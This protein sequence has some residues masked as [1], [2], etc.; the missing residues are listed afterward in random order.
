MLRLIAVLIFTCFILCL[1]AQTELRWPAQAGFSFSGISYTGD[2]SEG[3]S[4][5]S[6]VYPGANFS[7]QS[8][9][10][11]P[12]K[13]QLNAG[14]GKFAE[15]Y[16]TDSPSIPPGVEIP[17][18]IETSFIY[19]DLRLRY[20]FF[21]NKSFQPYLS[22][23]AGIM[24]FSPKDQDGKK[25][26]R[27]TSTRLEGEDFNDIIPE[28]PLSAGF[29]FHLTR[30]VWMDI[31]Y[32]YRY[33]PTDYLDNVGL[34]GE[35]NGFDALHSVNLGLHI[36]LGPKP[37]LSQPISESPIVSPLAEPDSSLEQTVEEG[38]EKS[39]SLEG[40]PTEAPQS[41]ALKAVLDKAAKDKEEWAKKAEKAIEN[42][43]FIYYRVKRGEDLESLA[44]KF[45]ITA[46][47][48]RKINFL[49]SP[50]IKAGSMLRLPNMGLDY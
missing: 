41:E 46:E 37:E 43:D 6:R 23:G 28:L 45:H 33:T 1:Q 8:S 21:N 39:P 49:S 14:F 15:Q 38:V 16:D 10:P 11:R 50:K 27:R 4:S 30:Q 25:L 12:L 48:I 17:T 3:S 2:Y 32:T 22:A 44:K 5:L 24:F 7:I 40:K 19:G 13:L 31:S 36:T 29:Y 42:D 35:N 26:V 20:H 47:M 18:F 34:A 9:N